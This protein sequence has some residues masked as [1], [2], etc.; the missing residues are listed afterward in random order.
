M[1]ART[2]KLDYLHIRGEH[3]DRIEK[4]FYSVVSATGFNL[5]DSAKQ[6]FS[7]L[8]AFWN[9]ME[10]DKFYVSRHD[11]CYRNRKYTNFKFNPV[12]AKFHPL[13]HE[14]YLQSAEMNTVAG[15]IEKDF[16]DITKD[17]YENRF[18]KELIALDA[19]YF[20]GRD[21]Y[22]DREWQCQ[23]HMIRIYVAPRKT[24]DVT[25][26]DVHSD[27]YPFAGV[28][29]IGKENISGTERGGPVSLDS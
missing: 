6:D 9:D 27:G 25:P 23:V 15:D 11:D 22:L 28:H 26:K 18:F 10:R 14:A 24:T 17:I 7:E 8:R 13:S 5:S 2:C 20:P 1:Q 4:N 19:R 3:A 16:G 29:F 12:T 21:A